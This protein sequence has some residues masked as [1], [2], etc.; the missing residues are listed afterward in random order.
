MPQL[1]ASIPGPTSSTLVSPS[2]DHD[3]A[4]SNVTGLPS[5]NVVIHLSSRK[6]ELL[7]SIG[8]ANED[9]LVKTDELSSVKSKLA[10]T[11]VSV[12][13][14]TKQVSM[15]KEELCSVNSQ[16]S[17]SRSAVSSTSEQISMQKEELSSLQSGIFC[18]PF[19]GRDCRACIWK[20]ARSF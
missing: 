15:K 6:R 5:E 16:L 13:S 14:L 20:R 2:E 19:F 7:E 18:P 4:L 17:L 11:Q 8:M 9:L 3:A 12:A 1:V 10:L